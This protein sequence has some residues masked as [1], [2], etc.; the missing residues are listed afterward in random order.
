VS[1]LNLVG[2]G[3]SIE[4]VVDINP[5][6]QGSYIAGTG[7]PVVAPDRLVEIA[8]DV[9]VVMNPVYRKEIETQLDAMGLTPEILVV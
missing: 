2:A 3:D 7:Q 6:K 4:W 1:F 9:V 5:G 8:P